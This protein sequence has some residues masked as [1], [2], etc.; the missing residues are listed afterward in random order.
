MAYKHQTCSIDLTQVSSSDKVRI[1][2]FKT[3]LAN[4]AIQAEQLHELEVEIAD[5]PF[6]MAEGHK[7]ARGEP[8]LY[9]ELI[10]IF[11]NNIRMYVLYRHINESPLTCCL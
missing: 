4:V 2:H 8:S 10:E 1:T 7:Q 3:L 9:F 5:M 6:L 11:I